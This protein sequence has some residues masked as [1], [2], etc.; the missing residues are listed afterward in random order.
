MKTYEE[1]VID[2]YDDDHEG[3]INRA[4][5][6]LRTG[7]TISNKAQILEDLSRYKEEID[8]CQVCHPELKN[9]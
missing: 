9:F 3:R 5:T 4:G 2:H 6:V 8:E 7:A 1:H